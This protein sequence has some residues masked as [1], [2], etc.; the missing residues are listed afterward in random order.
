MISF[1]VYSDEA[2]IN[3]IQFTLTLHFVFVSLCEF[4]KQGE[5]QENSK[6]L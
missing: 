1:V 4:Q 2:I 5:A 3:K 6:E